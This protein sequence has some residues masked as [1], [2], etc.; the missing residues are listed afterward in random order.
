[1]AEVETNSG[2]VIKKLICSVCEY[3]CG[4]FYPVRSAVVVWET[5]R[6]QEV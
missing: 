6:E 4:I 5:V 1:M 2:S 3:S